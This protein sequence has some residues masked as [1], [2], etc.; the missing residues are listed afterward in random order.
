MIV[1]KKV[2]HP[3]HIPPLDRNAD[4]INSE[5]LHGIGIFAL[6]APRSRSE[7]IRLRHHDTAESQANFVEKN[8]R[9]VLFIPTRLPFS[10]IWPEHLWLCSVIR[11]EK[12]DHPLSFISRLWSRRRWRYLSP[13]SPVIEVL[14]SSWIISSLHLWFRNRRSSDYCETI[15]IRERQE[16]YLRWRKTSRKRQRWSLSPGTEETGRRAAARLRPVCCVITDNLPQTWHAPGRSRSR[17][18]SLDSGT[19]RPSSHIW[20]LEPVSNT[21][22]EDRQ[23]TLC[24]RA[25]VQQRTGRSRREWHEWHTYTATTAKKHK[26]VIH[27]SPFLRCLQTSVAISAGMAQFEEPGDKTKAISREV[28]RICTRACTHH[29]CTR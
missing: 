10:A 13:R 26:V 4:D 11:R 15:F 18:A 17:V 23:L 7:I 22:D 8:W 25:R 6:R 12:K 14:V 24:A 1:V 19:L 2:H 3:E 21:R 27:T 9:N 16:L 20:R 5:T 28:Q 29:D